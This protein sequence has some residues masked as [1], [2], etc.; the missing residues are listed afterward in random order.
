MHHSFVSKT[1]GSLKPGY[2][3]GCL[4]ATEDSKHLRL[5]SFSDLISLLAY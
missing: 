3:G 1:I 2:T 4:L 5:D